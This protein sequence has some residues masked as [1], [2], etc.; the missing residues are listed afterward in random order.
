[1]ASRKKRRSLARDASIG[2]VLG[3]AITAAACGTSSP[4]PD[5]GAESDSGSPD[6]TDASIGSAD[7]SVGPAADGGADTAIGTATDSGLDA[8]S[9][10]TTDSG[11]GDIKDAASDGTLVDLDGE[12]DRDGGG[13]GGGDGGRRDAGKAL[14]AE[15]S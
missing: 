8:G 4:S 2:A 5:G 6:T 10:G 14:D 1:M 7:T 3:A 11:T 13:A 12:A 15:T 9:D